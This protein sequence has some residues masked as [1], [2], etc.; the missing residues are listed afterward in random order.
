MA[1]TNSQYDEIKR[2][3]DFTRQQNLR[4]TYER[5]DEVYQKIPGFRQL[6]E[7]RT[8]VYINAAKQRLSSPGQD[9]TDNVDDRIR[10]INEKEASLLAQYGFPPDYLEPIYECLL[11][12]DTG[13]IDGKKCVC[14][15]NAEIRLLYRQY[16]PGIILAKENF[17]HF[18]FE[19]YSDTMIDG[20]ISPRDAARDAYDSSRK[21][22][23][24]IG[25]PS[26]NLLFLGNVGTGKSF[27]SH[28][29]AHEA[30]KRSFSTLCL[31]APDLFEITA[32]SKFGGDDSSESSRLIYDC[33]LLIIDD[34]GTE[35]T[36]SYISSELFHCINY[37][38]ERNRSTI[39]STNK[40][41]E[42]LRDLYSE[43]VTSRILGNYT[44]K[45]LIG[46]DIR[47]K[48]IT[49]ENQ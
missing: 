19:L 21:F 16:D 43:R 20:H 15:R 14:F 31:S 29:I 38:I 39:I 3:Y 17:S 8:S 28:C 18:S 36:N 5:K 34:L 41:L 10:A 37:R 48:K 4:E 25:K 23:E 30:I 44:I 11:C 22:I 2:R 49:G 13:Y 46:D 1:L 45:K 42:E 6:E 47:I 7:E 32:D 33:E 35:L 40:S 9:R 26:N 27:L 24:N 12:R